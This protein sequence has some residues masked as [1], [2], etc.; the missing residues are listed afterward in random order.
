M[1]EPKIWKT[2]VG[3][4]VELIEEAAFRFTPKGVSLRAMDPSRIA[5]VDFELPAEAF[6]EYDVNDEVII[7]VNLVEFDKALKR[8]K[9][10][11]ELTLEVSEDRSKLLLTFKGASTRKLGLPLIDMEEEQVPEPKIAFTAEVRIT[12]EVLEDG[13]R[14]AEMVSESVLMS[15]KKGEFVISA[16]SDRGSTELRL[17][18]GD[19]ALTGLEVQQPTSARFSLEYLL[20]MI[21][22]AS[23]SDEIILRLGTDLP[24]EM[25]IKLEKGKLRFFLAPRI[26]A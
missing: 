12:A 22:G 8:M 13:L 15:A 21:K 26:E 17:K 9:S 14:D 20:K 4:I 6:D 11:E 19:L 25:E 3:A 10:G 23:S 18:E 24:L 7:G 1:A 16:E 5:M 2:A